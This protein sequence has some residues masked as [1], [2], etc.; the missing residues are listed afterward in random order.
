[1]REMSN[2]HLHAVEE[3]KRLGFLFDDDGYPM[4]DPDEEF[5]M[6]YEM[7][8]GVLELLDVFS[9]Q[10]HSGFSAGY[11]L[12]ILEKVMKFE[13]IT[14]LTG[15]D[16]EWNCIND[17][18]TNNNEIFQNKRCSHVFK[19]N[20]EAYDIDGKIFVD[21]DGGSY[22]SRDSRVPVEFPYTPKRIYMNV[23]TEGN[24]IGLRES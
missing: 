2:Y 20:G 12:S 14:P 13:P 15:D 8:M 9:Q 3:M 22:T 16:D 5:D 18:R 17:D 10:G 21:P 23:D 19:E 1:M 7:S 4:E 24:E 6:N 11:A